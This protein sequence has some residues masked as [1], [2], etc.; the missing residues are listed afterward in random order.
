MPKNPKK[1]EFEKFYNDHIDKVYRFVFFRV[2]CDREL[3]QDL[4]SEIFLKAVEHFIDYDQRISTSAWIMTITRNHLANHWRDK[5]PVGLIP[6]SEDGLAEGFWLNSAIKFFKKEQNK[7]ELANLLEGLNIE[8]REIVTFHYLL[9]Y[10]YA[11]I[12]E[13]KGMTESA[14]KVAAHRAIK[15]LSAN[16]V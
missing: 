16:N 15:K 9:G 6:E 8:D 10:S 12:A 13:M 5:K 1:A 4:V 14:V 2:N 11:E 3:T 7:Q